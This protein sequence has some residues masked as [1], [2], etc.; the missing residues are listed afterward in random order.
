MEATAV[1]GMNYGDEGKGH[2]TNY[3]SN[4]NTLNIRS[5]GGAQASHAVFLSDGRS[6]IFHHFGSG[7][8]LGARTLL[9]S[10]FIVN[11][12]IFAWE[13]Q[14]LVEKAPMREIFIDP[15]CR[16]TTPYDMVINEFSAKFH[17]RNDTVGVGINETVE[18]SQYRQLRITARD[19]FEKSDM[20]IVSILKAIENDYLP[21]RIQQL[22]V[23]WDD[24][25]KYFRD[26]IR[27]GVAI[28]SFLKIREW[29]IG[30]VTVIWPDDSLVDKFLAKDK[31]RKIVFEAGQGM[32]L[33]QH[34]K[35]FMPYLT[36]SNTGMKNILELL[37]TIRTPLDLQVYLVTRTYLTRHGDGPIWNHV[38]NTFPF[39]KIEEPTNPDHTC[40]GK[41]RY[42]HLNKTWYDKAI[43]ETETIIKKDMPSCLETTEVSVAMTCLDHVG[44]KFAY[45]LDGDGDVVH[46]SIS[47]FPKIALIS[48]GRTERDVSTN[49]RS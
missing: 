23:P 9:A 18:R 41:M 22:N 16:I 44:P 24:F 47:D 36:R 20:E 40:Q 42:G 31:N 34:R 27:K 26:K 17:C 43:L 5:N 15:R 4:A 48:K 3:L 21:F 38:P 2:I 46:G 10:H 1:I 30:R 11:P 29:L 33:D 49:I 37:K 35:E 12:I 14:E 7:S 8:L 6:H 13:M 39:P 28:E 25:T 32:L 45:S 19:L